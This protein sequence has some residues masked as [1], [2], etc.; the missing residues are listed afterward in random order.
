MAQIDDGIGRQPRASVL[1]SQPSHTAASSAGT[2]YLGHSGGPW[3]ELTLGG[4]GAGAGGV[5]SY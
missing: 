1:D 5:D 2:F 3:I 4:G